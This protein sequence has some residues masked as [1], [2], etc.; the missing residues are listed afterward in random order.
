MIYCRRCGRNLTDPESKR[1]GIGKVCES[2]EDVETKQSSIFDDP[3]IQKKLLADGVPQEKVDQL[4][5]KY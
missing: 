3:L 2:K 4:K 1:K 5:R